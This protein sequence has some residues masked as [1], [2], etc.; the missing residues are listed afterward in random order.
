MKQFY[1][2]IMTNKENGTLY[3]GVTSNL[4]KRVWEHK[5]KLVE[6]FSK[7]YGLY[8]LVYYEIFPDAESAFKRETELKNWK[9]AWK[10]KLIN[11]FNPEWRDL[12]G[13]II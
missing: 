11:Q 13:N 9:R 4:P 7:K 5:D 10:L 2:Y 12:S 8:R 6:G 3:I 1:V